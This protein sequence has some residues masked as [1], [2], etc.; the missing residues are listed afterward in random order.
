MVID[1]KDVQ[2]FFFNAMAQGWVGGAKPSSIPD[3][4]GFT[5]F[6]FQ[7]GSLRLTD[8][9]CVIAH[10]NKSTGTTMIWHEE[11]PVWVMYYGGFYP[12]RALSLVKNSI[13][14]AYGNKKFYG[15]R[16]SPEHNKI[17]GLEYLNDIQQNE[18]RSFRGRETI[19]E[20]VKDSK[21]E[22]RVIGYHDYWGMSLMS[23]VVIL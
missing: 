23:D 11:T 7:E 19:V 12:S 14:I 13:R 22:T 18:F 5:T 4:P 2:E 16:G 3:L 6:T 15:G 21:T 1:L 10:N 8:R 17:E 20:L 9:Y